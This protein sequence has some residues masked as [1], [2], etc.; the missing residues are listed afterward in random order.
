MFFTGLQT[1]RRVCLELF[2]RKHHI[3]TNVPR[4]T[5]GKKGCLNPP[6]CKI[7]GV[8]DH[9]INVPVSANGPTS[10]PTLCVLSRTKFSMSFSKDVTNTMNV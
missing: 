1:Y 9:L 5:L 10:F 3:E 2:G 6:P 8:F 7:L 4:K